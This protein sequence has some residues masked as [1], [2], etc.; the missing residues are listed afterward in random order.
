MAGFFNY[1]NLSCKSATEMVEKRTFTKLTLTEKIQFKIHVSICK[2]CLSYQKQSEFIDLFLKQKSH[3]EFA[4]KE[5][6][7]L[8]EKIL[9]QLN[10][11]EK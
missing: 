4:N 2:A 3:F 11:Q 8:K 5:Y 9:F 10:E 1:L 6:Q 7:S